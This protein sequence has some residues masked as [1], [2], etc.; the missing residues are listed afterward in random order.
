MPGL[1]WPRMPLTTA[2]AVT[3]F[4]AL[5]YPIGTLAVV[6]GMRGRVMHPCSRDRAEPSNDYLGSPP[7]MLTYQRCAQQL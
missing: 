5:G 6:R 4:Y 1:S 2:S 3:F 7:I